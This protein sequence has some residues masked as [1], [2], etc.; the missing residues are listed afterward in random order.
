[1]VEE[2][3]KV[4]EDVAQSRNISSLPQNPQ[5]YLTKDPLEV[6]N[7]GVQ[8]P[9]I[10]QSRP[11]GAQNKKGMQIY[12]ADIKDENDTGAH[13]PMLANQDNEVRYSDED[14]DFEGP[15]VKQMRALLSV[16]LSKE[17]E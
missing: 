11:G 16:E 2:E 17:Q 9:E 6:E 12:I 5:S 1:M 10:I 4:G 15:K 3:S 8:L 14:D 13:N 7:S